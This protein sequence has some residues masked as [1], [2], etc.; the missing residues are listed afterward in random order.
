MLLRDQ[1]TREGGRERT[2]FSRA[3][4][5][6]SESMMAL[7]PRS[8][9]TFPTMMTVLPVKASRYCELMRGVDTESAIAYARRGGYCV[10]TGLTLGGC[11]FV[12][13][14]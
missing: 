8:W 5:A 6:P 13:G 14:K 1:S 10:R 3:V 2:R 12:V 11:L 4:T 9:V 7:S